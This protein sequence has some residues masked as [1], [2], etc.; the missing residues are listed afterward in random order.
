[1]PAFGTTLRLCSCIKVATRQLRHWQ[2]RVYLFSAS[3]STSRAVLFALEPLHEVVRPSSPPS[4]LSFP[5][6]SSFCP[7][8]LA[9][10]F[11]FGQMERRVTSQG[12]TK[13][14]QKRKSSIDYRGKC[15]DLPPNLPV[16]SVSLVGDFVDMRLAS[17]GPIDKVSDHFR[18][19]SKTC[20]RVRQYQCRG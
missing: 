18:D 1:M 5:A 19:A 20:R 7:F 12:S 17:F 4:S 6:L 16:A 3:Y 15:L 11:L 9:R 14:K 8:S 13:Q 10:R 2:K